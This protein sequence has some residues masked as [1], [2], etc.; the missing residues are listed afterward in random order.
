MQLFATIGI[1]VLH[2]TSAPIVAIVSKTILDTNSDPDYLGNEIT[3]KGSQNL[4]L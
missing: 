2:D 4:P 1:A 3:S